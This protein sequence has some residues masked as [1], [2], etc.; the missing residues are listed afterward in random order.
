[1]SNENKLTIVVTG[2]TDGIGLK[3]VEKLLLNGHN[4]IT[5]GLPTK[6][7]EYLAELK[8]NY[9][10]LFSL[11]YEI[12]F[13]KQGAAVDA[14]NFI[15]QITKTVDVLV[16]NVGAAKYKTFSDMTALEI[17]ELINVNFF[18]SVLMTKMLLPLMIRESRV[19]KIINIASIAAELPIFPNMVYMSCKYAMRAWT[20]AMQVELSRFKVDCILVLPGRVDTGFFDDESF[21][22]NSNRTG[23]ENPIS[24]DFVATEILKAISKTQSKIYLPK[25]Y[26]F[27]S[28][29][30]R[31]FPFVEHIIINMKMKKRIEEYYKIQR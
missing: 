14:F 6:H 12:D 18:N 21:K 19:A 9:K 22:K 7:T 20:Q 26:K 13:K 16:N 15:S 10:N 1:M 25:K 29:I 4:V 3:L 17:E 30:N 24:T 28:M 8:N 27:I 11:S 2:G 5:F 23:K 31:Y